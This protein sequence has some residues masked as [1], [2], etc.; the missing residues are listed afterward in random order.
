MKR[1]KKVPLFKCNVIHSLPGRVRIGCRALK[2]LKDCEKNIEKRIAK[3]NVIKSVKVNI[4]TENVLINYKN[5][6]VDQENVLAFIEEVLSYYTVEAH[7]KER[8]AFA[9]KTVKEREIQQESLPHMI[10]RIGIATGALAYSVIKKDENI[11]LPIYKKFT[12]VQALTSLYLSY[13]FFKSGIS[14]LKEDLRPNADAL[15]V[16]SIIASLL[17]GNGVSSL[18]IILLSD[19]AELLT[20][21]T[22]VQTRKSIEDMLSLKEEYAWKQIEDGSVSK[23]KIESLKPEDLVI[24]HAGEKIT[25]DGQVVCGEAVVDQSS[26]TG[27][28]IPVIKKEKDSVFAGT[29]VKNGDITI[30]TEKAGDKTVVS[31]IVHLVEDAVYQRAPIQNYADQF[32]SYLIPFNFLFA[33]IT[34][35]A[36]KSSSRALNMLVIDFSCGIRLST[37]AAFSA[38]INTAVRNGVLIK[39]GNYI[40]ALSKADTLILDKT[41]TL[42]EG[43]PEVKTIIKAKDYMDEKEI[44][45][46]AAAA[47]EVS[48]HPMAVA[49]LNKARALALEIP[50]HKDT[51]NHISRGIETIVGE[52]LIRV[53]SK[54]FMIENKIDVSFMEEKLEKNFTTG[55][56][57][58][59]V[60]K[61]KKLLGSIIIEDKMRENMKKSLNNLRYQGINEMILLTGDTKEQAEIV[62]TKMGVDSFEAELLPEDK[63]KAILKLQSKGSGV[64][65]IGDGI[66]DA[67]ALSYADVG[68][69]L[70]KGTTDVAMETSDITV[71]LDNPMAIPEIT[72]MSKKTMDIISE[73]FGIVLSINSLGLI[74]G[75]AGV[76]PVFWGA[77]LHNSSTIFVVANSLRLFFYNF[78]RSI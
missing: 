65:M 5:D 63:A 42:T 18:M 54:N 66:N 21:Y 22:M 49:V 24:V 35:L 73:N 33:G 39:G 46:L 55:Q 27:E 6:I 53:G 20:S 74:L 13:P 59:Y 78:E 36:T 8:E 19:I 34:Y 69:S 3:I 25:V 17:A 50:K 58:I 51:K 72:V 23:V 71:Q 67:P 48:K 28:F 12:T 7:K 31:R 40:E 41:G 62:A 77:V 16:S 52:D 11:G 37:A 64:I 43:R 68:I 29:L 30:K 57:I 45:A 9:K 26:V 44:L 1:N 38:A 14:S 61:N 70:G 15:T 2:Y 4:L 76:L 10:K 47:E 56:N 60:S 32:S 75:A